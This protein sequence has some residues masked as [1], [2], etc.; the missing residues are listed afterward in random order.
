[1][2][3]LPAVSLCRF[4]FEVVPDADGVRQRPADRDAEPD[5]RDP[6]RR[7]R[8]QIGQRHAGAQRSNGQDDR[9]HGLVDRPVVAA[10]QEQDADADIARAFD[11]QVVDARRDDL[12]LAGVNE[13]AHERCGKGAD[14]HA[15]EDAER[16]TGQPGAADAL[17][18]ALA[19]PCPVVLGHVGGKGVA[20]ILHRHV[21]EGIDLDRRRKGRHDDDAEAVHKALHHQDAEVHDG[22]LDAGHDR[23]VQDGGEVPLVPPAVGAA[24]AK[25]GELFQGIKP[26]AHARHILGKDRGSRRPGD[27]PPQHD[28]ARTRRRH[29]QCAGLLR[30]RNA[31]PHSTGLEVK[32]LAVFR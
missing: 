23:E 8:E 1:M 2:E 4:G 18:D 10:E 26:D 22:L 3:R 11:A 19:L 13:D 20:E 5:A 17:A 32:N 27:A 24:R 6:Q 30:R 9:H 14:Q 25:A 15:D 7:S 28:G 12:A 29:L 31:G 16:R 21:G